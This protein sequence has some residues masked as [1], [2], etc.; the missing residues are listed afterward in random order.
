VRARIFNA[1]AASLAGELP[2]D[3]SLPQVWVDDAADAPRARSII[4][5]FLRTRAS[6]PPVKC[7]DCGEEN[8]G[9]FD[10]CWSCGHDLTRGRNPG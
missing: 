2:I 1:N 7:P 8:P 4:E 5:E 10:L 3:A 9:S 6:G